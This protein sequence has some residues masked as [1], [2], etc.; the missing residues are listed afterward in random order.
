M[1]LTDIM[2][3]MGLASYAEFALVLFLFAFLII[4]IQLL[5]VRRSEVDAAAAL[6]LDDGELV[7]KNQKG[8]HA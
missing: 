8:R 4:A 2:S 5:F 6:P 3:S 1:R 7:T